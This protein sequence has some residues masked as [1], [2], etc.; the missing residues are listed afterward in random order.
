MAKFYPKKEKRMKRTTVVLSILAMLGFANAQFQGG[1][2][3]EVPNMRVNAMGGVYSLLETSN[4]ADFP[5]RLLTGQEGAWLGTNRSNSWG[6]VRYN[7]N[8]FLDLPMPMAWQISAETMSEIRIDDV[9][10]YVGLC[11]SSQLESGICSSEAL[12]PLLQTGSIR[13]SQWA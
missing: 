9:S 6:L 11:R 1:L 8:N 3:N 5:Q 2:T 7:L 10:T 4:Y 12:M 13:I